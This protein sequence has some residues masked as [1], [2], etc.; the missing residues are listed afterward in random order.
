MGWFFTDRKP[1][2]GGDPH[3]PCKLGLFG[4]AALAALFGIGLE[5]EWLITLAIVLLAA[6]LVLRL[7][8]RRPPPAE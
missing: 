2:P 4:A 7:L 8:P 5:R 3:L 6:G 1:R